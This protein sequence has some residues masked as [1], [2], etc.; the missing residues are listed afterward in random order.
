MHNNTFT[1]E[2]VSAAHPDKVC[3]SISDSVVDAALSLYPKSRVALETMVTKNLIVMAGEVT[4]PKTLDYVSI[5]RKQITVLGY[6]NP[7]YGFSDKS[8]IEVYVHEQSPDISTGVDSDGAGDQGMMFG[9]ACRQTRQLMP[10]PV[11]VAHRLV[12]SLDTAR[13]TKTLPYLLP[14]GKS[15]VTIEYHGRKAYKA[16]QVVIA[17]PHTD[18]TLLSQVKQDVFTRIVKPVLSEFDLKLSIKDFIIN[19]T[20]VW[21]QGGPAADTGVTGRKIIVDTYGGY[22][23]VGGGCF[24]GKDPTKVDR[25][26]A[27][28]A[29]FLAKNIVAHKLALEAEV[30]LAY[31][32]GAKNPVM[33][34]VETFGTAKKS[35]TV[36]L[37]FCNK[38][39]D[40]SVSGILK[41][42]KL[43]QP[44]YAQT[45]SYGH[46][47]HDTYPWEQIAEI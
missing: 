21:H 25:S 41:T 2:S 1:S 24:S 35:D 8:K 44:I 32:I 22:A 5:A 37:S 30:R 47:G 6:T 38:I 12:E 23:R 14:D 43:R 45:S 28:A 18:K 42:L 11:M 19:G 13:L 10:L 46:F 9:Y 20:G 3:D 15:Q 26:G 33:L 39:L 34:S 31:Y 27:Y 29:R 17:V 16:S 36:I 7:S 40:T 4:C